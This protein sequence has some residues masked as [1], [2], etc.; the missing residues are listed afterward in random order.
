ME[1]RFNELAEWMGVKISPHATAKTLSVANHQMLEIMR[2][3][4]AE[5]DVIIMDEPTAPLGPFE[6][7]RLYDLIG[8]LKENN[9]SI[10]FI[11]HDLDEVLRLCD[12]VSV[13]RDG[14]LIETRQSSGWTKDSLVK[15]MLGDIQIVAGRKREHGELKP[16]LRVQSLSLP[17]EVSGINFELGEGEVLG[18]AGLVGAGRT[19]VLRSVAGLE[20]MAEGRMTIGGEDCAW[21]QSVREAIE[22]GI[23]LAPED[24]KREGL[25]LSR[26]ALCNLLLADIGSGSRGPVISPAVRRAKATM[27]A[28]QI[29]FDPDRLDTDALHLSGGNQQ[30]LVIGKWLHRRPRILLL[31]EPTRGIDLGAKQEIFQTIRGLSDEG[32]GVILVS[33][34]LEEVVEHADRILVMARGKQIATLEGQEASVE[35]ILNLIFAVEGRPAMAEVN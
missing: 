19:E 2:A 35:R 1:K 22:R 9:V 26:S 3:V 25:V 34:D 28:K 10:I 17:G 6:R 27:L 18:I 16:L 23:A 33:S 11:S 14:Q 7:S 24:R 31:D 13:M 4:H 32:M 5:H 20:S 29:G 8:R 21:P 12:R 30:K 15:T